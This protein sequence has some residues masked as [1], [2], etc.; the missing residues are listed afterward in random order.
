MKTKQEQIEEIENVLKNEQIRI[1][2]TSDGFKDLMKNGV[3]FVYSKAIYYAGYRKASD[4]IDEFVER[5]IQRVTENNTDEG[6]LDESIDY[7]C[8]MDDIKELAVEML[9]R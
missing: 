6:Y 9:Q 8:L 7:T 2:N 5:L 1:A 3:C 4:V